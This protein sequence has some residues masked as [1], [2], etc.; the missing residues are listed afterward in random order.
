M[1]DQRRPVRADDLFSIAMVS[2]P[3]VSPDGA[4]VVYVLT[5]LDRDQNRYRSDLW[6]VRLD[7][8]EPRRLTAARQRDGSPR[9]SP[10]GRWIVF[11][12]SAEKAPAQLWVIP[13][14][15]GEARRLTDLPESAE[16]LAWAPD[17]SALAFVSKVRVGPEPEPGSDVKVIRTIRYRFDGEGFLDDRY[18]Q[19]WVIPFDPDSGAAG[20][21]RCLT[22]GPFDHRHPA[23]APSGHEI[24]FQ[25][26]RQPGWELGVSVD[27]WAIRPSGGSPR[28]ITRSVGAWTRPAWSPDGTTIALLGPS[29]LD[30]LEHADTLVW[31][32]PA[33]G[34]EPVALTR[35]LDRP[36]G[37]HVM[38]DVPRFSTSPLG[39]SPTG[40]EVYFQ[41]TAQGDSALYRVEIESRRIDR[42]I[43]G[44]R[45]VGMVAPLPGASGWV[46]AASTPTE[47]GDLFVCGPDGEDERRLTDVNAAWRSEVALSAPEELWATSGD[48]TRVQGWLLRPSTV[49]PGVPVP[50]V[51][52][53]HGGPHAQ[54]GNGFM[55]EFQLLAGLGYAVLYA[56]PRGSTGYGEE[57]ALRL[58]AAWG[59]AD[60]PD[61]MAVLDAAIGR[62]GIDAERLGVTGGSYGGIM[63][64]WL[65]GHTD[66]FRA[67]VTQRCCSNY[68]SMYGTDDISFNTARLTFDAE[69]WEDPELYWRL[70]PITYVANVRTPLLIVHSEEDYRCPVEQAEQLYTALKRRRQ[71]VEFVRFPN[72][73]HGLSRGGQPRHRV[74]RLEAITGWFQRYL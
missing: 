44:S 14:T 55:F 17:G 25:A 66:R 68:V 71:T 54:Y 29:S 1:T 67:A 31:I 64:N 20:T 12:S 63:T 50:L 57:F 46:F 52:E 5:T 48:G 65:I 74:E 43:A 56:N 45:R 51:L 8:R 70:S 34:G 37:D 2:D 22:D 41:A 61:L 47:P 6:T 33:S 49:Q 40:R 58:H 9:W 39:W 4:T 59:E 73:S 27:L 24:A 42:I 15:G 13:A 35:A 23:W 36:A 72:E 16:Q 30:N 10:D 19:L 7:G 60:M 53:I 69:V 28:R 38:G 26:A 32:V 62:G 11:L 21:A 3:Q 18:R